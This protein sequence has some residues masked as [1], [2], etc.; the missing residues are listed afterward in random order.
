MRSNRQRFHWNYKNIRNIAFRTKRSRRTY[1]IVWFFKN[2]FVGGDLNWYRASQREFV[3]LLWTKKTHS[4]TQLPAMK[5]WK[6][7]FKYIS[8][9]SPYIDVRVHSIC[10]HFKGLARCALEI[11]NESVQVVRRRVCVTLYSP[12]GLICNWTIRCDMKHRKFKCD[13]ISGFYISF[14]I[15]PDV[16]YIYTDPGN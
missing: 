11:P 6:V 13:P 3:I 5:Y 15:W 4:A 1:F 8:E 16:T 14:G 10:K 7:K 9:Y 2:N 12:N